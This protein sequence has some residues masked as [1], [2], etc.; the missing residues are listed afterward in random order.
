MINVTKTYLPDKEKYLSYIDKIY[1]SGWLTNNGKILQELEKRLCN[2]LDVKNIILVANGTLALQVAFKA[3]QLTGEVITTPFSFVATTSSIVWE[4][5]EPVF[6]D[7]NEDNFNIDINKIE[8]KI[9]SK[10]SAL[11]PVHVFGNICDIES[12]ET[13]SK[14]HSLKVI[15]DAAHCFGIKYKNKSIASYGD[16]STFSFHSTKVFHTIEGGAIIANDDEIFRKCKLM[17]NFGIPDYDRISEL[18]INCKMNEFQ[19]AMGLC[20]LDDFEKI[21]SHRRDIYEKYLKAFKS[22][23]SVQLQKNNS[24]ATQNYS[25]FPVVFRSEETMLN[26]KN[27]LNAMNIFPRRYF[28]PSLET[29]SYL[30][31]KQ[32]VPVSSSLAKRILCLPIHEDLQDNIQN[33]IIET[34]LQNE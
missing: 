25:Y 19:A 21:I 1:S 15:Y 30:K 22:L 6:V 27:Q 24:A 12:I 16:I 13:I 2:Y 29:L 26:I 20:V 18:G 10:T 5:L 23:S 34:I 28:Y 9:T 11:V 32:H 31:D 7:I 14:Q 8:E 17:I 3:L 33:L 4:G